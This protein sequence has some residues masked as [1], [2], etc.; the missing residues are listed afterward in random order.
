MPNANPGKPCFPFLHKWTS[1]AAPTVVTNSG[2]QPELA[3]RR[4]CRRCNAVDYRRV[5]V[6]N[7]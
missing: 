1:Y 4:H 6:S 5:R 2:G 3:Q 7:S